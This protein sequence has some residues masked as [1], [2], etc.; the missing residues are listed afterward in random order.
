MARRRG[1]RPLVVLIAM[2]LAGGASYAVGM[3][4]VKRAEQEFIS[5]E[6]E[7]PQ[8]QI[9]EVMASLRNHELDGIFET[10]QKLSPSLDSRDAYMEKLE[11]LLE[12]E[13]PTSLQAVPESLEE[14]VR[15][16]RL[17]QR[18]TPIGTMILLNEDGE[19]KPAIPIE[20]EESYTVEVPQ[21]IELEVYGSPVSSQYRIASG[22]QASNFFQVSDSS[23]IP[24]VDIY[25]FDGL[26]GAPALNE[27]EGYSMIQDVLSGNWLLGKEVIDE[28]LKQELIHD[29]ELIAM[30]PAED[31]SLASVT[32][33]SDTTSSWYRKYVTL[34]NYWF[35]AHNTMELSNESIQ[36]VM[37]SEDTIVA[38]ITF[39]YYA[40]NG[41][42]N[43]TWHVGY[44]LTFRK[45]GDTWLVCGTELNSLLNPEQKH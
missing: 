1:I 44:Q 17:L 14:T 28:A 43:R 23:I 45:S 20:G 33:I 9:E 22:Q 11:E 42:V 7:M 4:K 31:T 24:I 26:L 3:S 36:A 41:E 38:H 5:Y 30:Y 13:D 34:Q 16:Y 29:A 32:A 6:Q 12:T 27:A 15:T 10:T 18:N 19:W 2:A 37:Q 21:G 39:D 8:V 35:T 25:Q 40:D